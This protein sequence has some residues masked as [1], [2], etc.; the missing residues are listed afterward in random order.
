MLPFA[1]T[2][3]EVTLLVT[4]AVSAVGAIGSCCAAAIAALITVRVKEVHELTNSRLH[5]IE[6]QLAAVTV[7]RNLLERRASAFIAE[8]NL[9]QRRVG[10]TRQDPPEPAG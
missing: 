10:D 9:L 6:L 5:S 8:R 7:E 3:H 4:L 1:L 2:S